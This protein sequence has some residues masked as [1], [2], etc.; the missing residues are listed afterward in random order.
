MNFLLKVG[1]GLSVALIFSNIAVATSNEISDETSY[2]TNT[3]TESRHNRKYKHDG[4]YLNGYNLSTLVKQHPQYAKDVDNVIELQN[5]VDTQIM[6]L[7]SVKQ[8]PKH[9]VDEIVKQAK[10]LNNLKKQLQEAR[11]NLNN[12]LIQD[13]VYR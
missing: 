5:K 11:I 9:D 13:N 3:Y 2:T 6:V 7:R 10:I 1:G 12:K 4:Y 8:D